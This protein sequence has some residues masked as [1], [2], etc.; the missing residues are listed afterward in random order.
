[1]ASL[2]LA[3]EILAG[4]LFVPKETISDDADINSLGELDSL[5]FEMIVM[6]IERHIGGEV[7]PVRLLGLQTVS[8]LAA[9]LEKE[10]A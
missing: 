8:D 6:E 1:M 9:M 3:K 2:D 5:T 10:G 4:C 7:D